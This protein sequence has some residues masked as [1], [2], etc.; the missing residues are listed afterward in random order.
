MTNLKMYIEHL[1]KTHEKIDCSITSYLKQKADSDTLVFKDN[2]LNEDYRI[3]P[4]LG[5][6]RG[7]DHLQRLTMSNCGIGDHYF[8]RLLEV[9]T[10]HKSPICH[11]DVS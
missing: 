5:K 1:C 10:K 4:I 3:N 7:N 6:L 8:I 9:L 2:N 11:L